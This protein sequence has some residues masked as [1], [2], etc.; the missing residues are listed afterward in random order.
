MRPSRQL[1]D[2]QAAPLDDDVVVAP[3]GAD[4]PV[5]EHDVVRPSTARWCTSNDTGAAHAKLPTTSLRYAPAP[6]ITPVGISMRMS[7][8]QQSTYASTSS[9]SHAVD[10]PGEHVARLVDGRALTTSGGSARPRAC[11]CA[12]ADVGVEVGRA[13]ERLGRLGRVR[14]RDGHR[15]VDHLGLRDQ[16]DHPLHVGPLELAAEESLQLVGDAVCSA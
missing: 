10:P 12:V 8:C 16:R 5:G 15:R 1:A 6:S 11:A 3:A 13:G 2:R 4:R 14:A 9:A 7:S